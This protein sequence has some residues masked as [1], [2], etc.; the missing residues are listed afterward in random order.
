MSGYDNIFK[1]M[2]N[3]LM[4]FRIHDDKLLRKYKT[5]W[6]KIGDLKNIELKTFP[7][8]A[9]RY[10][11]TKKTYDYDVYNNFSDLNVPENGVVCEL[12]TV[13]SI[14]SLL[15]YEDKY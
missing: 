6:T 3:K 11:N 8:Y 5:I 4:Y 15:V 1:D 7:V 12:F 13:T 2:N 14:D 10:T 9:D